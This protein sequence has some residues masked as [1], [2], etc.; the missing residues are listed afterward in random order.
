M[1]ELIQR[2]TQEQPI[3]ASLRPS[4]TLEQLKAQVDRKHVLIKFT[5]TCGGTELGIRLDPERSDV[6]KAD[7]EKGTGSISLVGELVFDYVPV[8][9]HGDIDLA[10]LAGNGRLEI[11]PAR[12]SAAASGASPSA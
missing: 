3:I 7:F 6:S 10:T 4:P 1:N 9:F 2:L 12:T 11:L 8:R 5:E